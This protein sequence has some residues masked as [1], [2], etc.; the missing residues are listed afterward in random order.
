MRKRSA[1]A[2]IAALIVVI[3]GFFASFFLLYTGERDEAYTITLPGQGSA[4]FDPSPEIGESNREQLQTV[5]IDRTNIQ[6][7]IQ[8]LQ[9]PAQYQLTCKTTYFYGDNHSTLTSRVQANGAVLRIDQLGEGELPVQPTILTKD[10]VYLWGSDQQVMRFA[11][12]D[13]DADL[14]SKAPTYED[15]LDLPADAILE[16]SLTEQDGQLC[17]YA[18]SRDPL[19][20]EEEHWYILCENGLLLYAEG[21][22]DDKLTYQTAMSELSLAAPAAE[23]FLLPDGTQPE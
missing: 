1:A 16:G 22:L 8:K 14:Y 2:L 9:R 3:V 7:V 12:Q 6:M 15:L 4:V 5:Q 19:T 18:K 17:L 10:W 13:R 20:G 23:Q 21:R 11:R